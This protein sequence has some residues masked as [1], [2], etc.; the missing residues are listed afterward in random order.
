MVSFS[1]DKEEDKQKFRIHMRY[2][3]SLVKVIC[4]SCGCGGG[5]DE[6]LEVGLELLLLLIG[7]T[8]NKYE[9][10][11]G[12]LEKKNVFAD[13]LVLLTGHTYTHQNLTS[14]LRSYNIL[15]V[16]RNIFLLHKFSRIRI[17]LQ[18]NVLASLLKKKRRKMSGEKLHQKWVCIFSPKTNGS[19]F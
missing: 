5:C 16:C 12:T 3:V 6:R 7:F 8:W 17:S 4:W 18:D 10:C 1:S 9:M 14:F 13:L 2:A 19:S 11:K 15:P